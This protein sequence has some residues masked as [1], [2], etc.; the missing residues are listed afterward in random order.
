MKMTLPSNVNWIL[1]RLNTA[2]FDA[3]VV[4]GCVRDTLLGVA[5]KDWDVCTSA[6]PEEMQRVFSGCHVVETGLK[7]GTLTVVLDHEPYEV[8]TFRVDGAYTDHRHPDGV[9]FVTDVR[10][11]LA[12][13]DFTVNAMAF[14]PN[15]GLIDCF[16]G[17][18]DLSAR[19]IRCVGQPE[20]RFE[21]D[22]LRILRA[23]RFASTYDF[24]IDPDTAAAI[25]ALYPTLADVAAERIHVELT[26]LLCG[27]G[28]GRI[29]REYT[30]VVTFLIPE[31]APCVGFEQHNHH[32]R[33][34]VWEHIVRAVENVSPTEVLRMA[35][36]LHD[37]G[38]PESFF[39]G[40]D[41]EGHMYGH[42]A[43]SRRISEAVLARLKLDNAARDRILLLVEHHDADLSLTERL[44]RRRLSKYGED[45]LRQLFDF[46]RADRIA[47]GTTTAAEQDAWLRDANAL[48]DHVLAQQPCVSVKQLAVNGGDLMAAGVPRGPRLGACLAMLL[49]A[50]L[51]DL[52]PNEQAAL[53]A[54]ARTWMREA[55]KI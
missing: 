40:D 49:D 41:G 44:V 22:A 33:Y 8:T 27:K 26:K 3:Y 14:N 4:G 28:V 12:R 21:E 42:P 39:M 48:L 46:R 7:H 55:D 34:T 5:P 31:L 51:E 19:R 18:S 54:L 36:L 35:A 13:R 52:V 20:R 32:H 29:L 53:L 38:K 2:G 15:E 24:A 45:A 30:D 16:D 1:S 11:D 43:V 47:T 50:V 10:E 9:T 6:T 37:A 17:Q 23:L 25:H